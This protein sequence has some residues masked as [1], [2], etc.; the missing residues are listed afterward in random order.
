MQANAYHGRD[1]WYPK[2][3]LMKYSGLW[4]QGRFLKPWLFF[5]LTFYWS[6]VDLQC[7]ISFRCTAKWI[8]YI[9]TYIH[10]FSDSFPILS[11]RKSEREKQIYITYMWNLKKKYK[12][13]YIQNRNRLTDVE[14]LMVT[15]RQEWGEVN[16]Q[17]G[18]DIHTLLH[19]I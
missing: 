13:T 5:F 4:M 9:C 19:I 2:V 6:I 15:R 14:K 1:P 16:C 12:W 18:I 7:C 3:V 11:E 17:T 10:S 8:S